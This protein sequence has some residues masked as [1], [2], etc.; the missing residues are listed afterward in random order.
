MDTPTPLSF[1]NDQIAAAVAKA[2]PQIQAAIQFICMEDEVRARRAAE[3]GN[4]D[5]DQG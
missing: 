1:T 4:D 5:D 3:E 2:G